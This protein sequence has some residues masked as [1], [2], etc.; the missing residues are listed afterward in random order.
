MVPDFSSAQEG[1]ND[2]KNIKCVLS[3]NQVQLSLEIGN[4]LKFPRNSV[5]KIWTKIIIRNRTKTVRSSIGN[6]FRY[7]ING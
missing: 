5:H 2:I 7:V 4:R 1:S 3:Y 6:T